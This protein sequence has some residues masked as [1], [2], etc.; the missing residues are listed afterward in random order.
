MIIMQFEPAQF[1][2]I[3][4]ICRRYHVQGLQMFGSAAVVNRV[5]HDLPSVAS[6]LRQLVNPNPGT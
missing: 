1:S 6:R 2:R 3:A 5:I 4:D